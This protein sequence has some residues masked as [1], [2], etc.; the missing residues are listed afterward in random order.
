MAL[1]VLW[2]IRLCEY[3]KKCIKKKKICFL[4][5][6]SS[7]FASI[8]RIGDESQAALSKYNGR[9]VKATPNNWP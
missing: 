2:L 6:S 8:V 1:D 3:T 9:I 5:Y 4:Y 7:F